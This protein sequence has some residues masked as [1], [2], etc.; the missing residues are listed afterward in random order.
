M[1]L[2]CQKPQLLFSKPLGAQNLG[3]GEISIANALLAE[4][5]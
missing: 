5:V 3:T 1:S 2:E 4:E